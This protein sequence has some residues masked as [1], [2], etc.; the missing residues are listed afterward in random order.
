MGRLG[1]QLAVA[2]VVATIGGSSA[3]RTENSTEHLRG[4]GADH[5]DYVST[6]ASMAGSNPSSGSDWSS[7][8]DQQLKA[9]N[10]SMVKTYNLYIP[11]DYKHFAIEPTAQ[12]ANGGGYGGSQEQVPAD[13]ASSRLESA[14]HKRKK[15]APAASPHTTTAAPDMYYYPPLRSSFIPREWGAKQQRIADPSERKQRGYLDYMKR[16]VARGAGSQRAPYSKYIPAMPTFFAASPDAK[17]DQSIDDAGEQ[18][19]AL[20]AETV[21][22]PKVEEQEQSLWIWGSAALLLA[23]ALLILGQVAPGPRRLGGFDGTSERVLLL[24]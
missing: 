2:C 12:R 22:M 17:N 5:L 21:K 13:A 3:S 15:Q 20:A 8:Q 7:K 4:D 10:K 19:V 23:F 18:E 11:G 1:H 14:S 6:Y 16:Y 9:W 24:A